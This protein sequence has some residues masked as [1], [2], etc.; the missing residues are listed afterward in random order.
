[1]EEVGMFTAITGPTAHTAVAHAALLPQPTR[2][3]SL[4]TVR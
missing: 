2:R 3:L 1:M 4:S